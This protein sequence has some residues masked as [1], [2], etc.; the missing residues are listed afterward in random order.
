MSQ[1]NNH[2]DIILTPFIMT[3]HALSNSTTVEEGNSMF[4]TLL[5]PIISSVYFNTI[6]MGLCASCI[7]LA[8]TLVIEKWGSRVGGII[9]SIPTAV[10][11]STM[12]FAL[13]ALVKYNDQPDE[14]KHVMIRSFYSIPIGTLMTA[15]FLLSWKVL[16]SL[17]E[18]YLMKR[19]WKK[20]LVQV[21]HEFI[22]DGMSLSS[23]DQDCHTSI[24]EVPKATV[25]QQQQHIV[26]SE[27]DRTKPQ[28]SLPLRPLPLAII[29]QSNAFRKV[30]M[31]SL[32]CSC[33]VFIWLL[34]AVSYMTSITLVNWNDT[35]HIIISCVCFTVHVALA[36]VTTWTYKPYSSSSSEAAI[37]NEENEKKSSSRRRKR[38]AI[39]MLRVALPF[40]LVSFSV[41]LNAMKLTLLAGLAA[42]FPTLYMTTLFTLWIGNDDERLAVESVGPMT[43][44]SASVSLYAIAA[45]PIMLSKSLVVGAVF[46]YSVAVGMINIPAFFYLNWRKSVH[47]E[48]VERGKAMEESLSQ[49]SLVFEES[50][51]LHSMSTTSSPSQSENEYT[52]DDTEYL[53]PTLPN[54]TNLKSVES[55][56]SLCDTVSDIHRSA[57]SESLVS[58]IS[59]ESSTVIEY[60]EISK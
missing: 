60:N 28:N 40:C 47:D 56:S 2:L 3:S 17:I 16:P 29:M 53:S 44:G 43:L 13:D 4:A 54:S 7:S 41:L 18:T 25:P 8:I 57:S 11:P 59:Q 27:L 58:S 20:R 48:N 46:A 23:T 50:P 22:E 24:N 55:M 30:F 9:G 52:Y 51:Q 33:G 5:Y 36:V 49:I 37:P 21:S 39:L 45:C 38:I 32:V 35:I 26:E 14:R 34:L 6:F 1:H 15:V 10:V 42:S 31:A 19:F 12:G